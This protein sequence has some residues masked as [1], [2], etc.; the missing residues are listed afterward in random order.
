MIAQ[1]LEPLSS[2]HVRGSKQAS[3]APGPRPL[4]GLAVLSHQSGGYAARLEESCRET[5]HEHFLFYVVQIQMNRMKTSSPLVH[6]KIRSYGSSVC[7]TGDETA[8]GV[9]DLS[10]VVLLSCVYEK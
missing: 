3:E 9:D 2:V 6:L 8:L 7:W 5:L 4:A 1:V 10:L